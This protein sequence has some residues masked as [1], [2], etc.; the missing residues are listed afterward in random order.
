MKS[1]SLTV[2]FFTNQVLHYKSYHLCDC[3]TLKLRTWI[4][5]GHVPLPPIHILIRHWWQLLYCAHIAVFWH[6]FHTCCLN[7]ID[8]DGCELVILRYCGERLTCAWI[9][10]KQQWR[11]MSWPRA[12]RQ[13]IYFRWHPCLRIKKTSSIVKSSWASSQW[14][15]QNKIM[16]EN[17]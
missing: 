10:V 14:Y 17:C 6:W 16:N 9:D 3:E 8:F 1:C 13:K 5:H 15:D 12:V 11:R 4:G 2:H 7:V